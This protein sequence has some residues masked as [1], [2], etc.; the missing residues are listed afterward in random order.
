MTL[1]TANKS[2]CGTWVQSNCKCLVVPAKYWRR[3]QKNS[4]LR[5]IDK[6]LTYM[7]PLKFLDTFSTTKYKVVL[8][9]LPVTEIG[10][11]MLNV[12]I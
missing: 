9:W 3:Q 5:T 7:S 6:Y 2:D 8:K 11:K 10:C 4:E 1:L 12:D